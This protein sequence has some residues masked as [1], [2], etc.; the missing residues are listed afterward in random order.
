MIH[1][2]ANHRVTSVA[3]IAVPALLLSACTSS[4]DEADPGPEQ[5]TQGA[6][7]LVPSTVRTG[8]V[9]G[10]LPRKVADQATAD[11]AAVVEAWHEAAY[12]GDYPRTEFDWPGFRGDLAEQARRDRALTS[13][14][15]LGERIEGV[16]PRVRNITVDLLGDGGRPVGA[17][18]RFRLIFDTSGRWTGTVRLKGRLSLVPDG[19][20]WQVFEYDVARGQS[21]RAVEGEQ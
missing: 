2:R 7:E 11:V 9:T 4:G 10:R 6:P 16:T 20:G 21:R 12:L 5:P 18:A 13:N 17:T 3:L 8:R 14:A 19:K 1:R 15:R